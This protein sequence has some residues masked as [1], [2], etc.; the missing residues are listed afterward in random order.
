MCTADPLSGQPLSS[1]QL[2]PNL[3]LRDMIHAWLQE[4]P[5]SSSSSD[6]SSLPTAAA[7]VPIAAAG[8]QRSIAAD[9]GADAGGV[10]EG[11]AVLLES[12]HSVTPGKG[13]RG[14]RD[15]G[16]GKDVLTPCT[17]VR[18]SRDV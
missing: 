6:S 9:A 3:V 2:V 17:P 10:G 18:T 16:L 8:A 11:F 7:D 15:S 4:D 1:N 14:V 5:S 12:A 13:G